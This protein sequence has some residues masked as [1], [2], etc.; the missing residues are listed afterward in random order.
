M[1]NYPQPDIFIPYEWLDFNQAALR[2]SVEERIL[3]ESSSPLEL[4][5]FW[6]CLHILCKSLLCF[7]MPSESGHQVTLD[8]KVPRC[9]CDLTQLM[10]ALPRSSLSVC[11]LTLH[12]AALPT[13]GSPTEHPPQGTGQ[14]Q[15]GRES[16]ADE[17]I[18]SKSDFHQGKAKHGVNQRRTSE[19]LIF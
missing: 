9:A 8:Q 1:C 10:A 18:S 19:L 16:T 15:E 7:P 12:T 3:W 17:E 13:P 11:P 14:Q 5:L 4:S 6:E 2:S